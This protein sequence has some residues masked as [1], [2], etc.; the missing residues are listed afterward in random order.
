MDATVLLIPA[1]LAA[2]LVAGLFGVGGGLV[3]VPALYALYELTGAWGDARMHMA[4]GTS[5]AAIVLTGVA[6]LRAHHRLRTIEWGLVI[7]LGSGLAVG[8]FLGA[9][10]AARLEADW[11]R[12]FFGLFECLVA[13]QMFFGPRFS[14][15]GREGHGWIFWS[16]AGLLIGSVSAL[17]GIGGG[18]LTVPLLVWSRIPMERAVG[19]SAACGVPIAVAGAAGYLIRGQAQTGGTGFVDPVAVL[20]LG[21]GGVL[22]APLGARLAVRLPRERLRRLFALFLLFVGLRMVLD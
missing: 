16:L 8:A 10:L 11:L 14:A 2:G 17:L 15:S 20:A 13:A 12:R 3:F 6:S 7:R 19:T 9:G 1:G 4:L 5:L 18:T 22:F 21:L